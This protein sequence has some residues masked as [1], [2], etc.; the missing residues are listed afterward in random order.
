[1]NCIYSRGVSRRLSR[2]R[3]RL[4]IFNFFRPSAAAAKKLL[5]NRWRRLETFGLGGSGWKFFGSQRQ[6][7]KFF[8]DLL[9][10]FLSFEK[11]SHKKKQRMIIENRFIRN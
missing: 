5:G 10:K 8:K 6:R 2:R 3:R 1:M 4:K 11:F 7:L 9:K